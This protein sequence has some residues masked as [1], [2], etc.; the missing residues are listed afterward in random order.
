[1]TQQIIW[2]QKKQKRPMIDGVVD[3]HQGTLRVMNEVA[4]DTPLTPAIP[5]TPSSKGAGTPLPA[6]VVAPMGDFELEGE[7][8]E[9]F[10]DPNSLP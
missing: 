2:F 5:S 8:V 1:M 9:S 7:S 10:V 6:K 3:P 4:L